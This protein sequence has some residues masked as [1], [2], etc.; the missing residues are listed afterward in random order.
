MNFIFFKRIYYLKYLDHFT[1]VLLFFLLDGCSFI[2]NI[3]FLRNECKNIFKKI[4]K[5]HK[6]KIFLSELNSFILLSQN[7]QNFKAA[8]LQ[9][10][11]DLIHNLQLKNQIEMINKKEQQI[12]E[13]NDQIVK[14][15]RLEKSEGILLTFF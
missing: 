4:I 3:L 10:T 14:K 11:A 12:C 2:L 1:F 9:Q 15:R 7:F 13:E 6:F 5:I 8:I